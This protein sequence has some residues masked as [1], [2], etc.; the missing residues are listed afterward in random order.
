MSHAP[1]NLDDALRAMEAGDLD[2]LSPDQVARLEA[3]LNDSPQAAARVADRVAAPEPRL[4]EALE[5]LETPSLPSPAAWSD[6]WARIDAE[7]AS[8]SG[9]IGN[10]TT[11]IIR[12]WKPLAAL[13]ACLCLAALWSFHSPAAPESWPMQL[14]TNVE[15]SQ[16]EVY[17]GATPFVISSGGENGYEIIWVLED[18]S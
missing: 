16:L 5:R 10:V 12:L 2:S 17:D 11:R 1:D 9:R 4:A 6:A 7:T 18:D 14:A 15:I 3:L 13:A 8:T